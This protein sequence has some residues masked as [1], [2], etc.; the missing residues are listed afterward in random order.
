MSKSSDQPGA[1][2]FSLDFELYW[3]VL[4]N[5]SIDSY[6]DRILGGR[7]AV[8][9]VLALA[10]RY[11]V[12]ATWA[13]VGFLFL[14]GPEGFERSRPTLEPSYSDRR[15]SPYDFMERLG[16]SIPHEL[17]FAR[18]LIEKVAATP[19]QEVATHTYSH[20][21]CQAR[22]ASL[23][24]FDAD[25]AA[26]CAVGRELGLDL[27]SIVF[28]RNQF[29]QAHLEV[30]REHGILAYRGNPEHWAYDFT[31]GAHAESRCRRFR[32][33]DAHLDLSGPLTAN[34]PTSGAEDPFNLPASWF[35]RPEQ[36]RQ[37]PLPWLRLRRIKR[38]MD[39]AAR[40]GTIFHLWAHPHNFG[41]DVGGSTC[42]LEEI[43][44]HY[45]QLREREGMSSLTMGEAAR[46]ACG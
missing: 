39:H 26:A 29:Q 10:E 2:M 5:R 16:G 17:L 32:I 25:I 41:G 11:E 1:F 24:E 38:A 31:G 36:P 15:Y 30:I 46:L 3:G 45:Q 14:D 28:P 8:P 40:T 4:H 43:F 35:L 12:H 42:F 34:W 7:A 22:G 18:D 19:G 9:K 20:F 23:A 27:Q 21:D 6:R 37:T 13:T 44:K 33:V